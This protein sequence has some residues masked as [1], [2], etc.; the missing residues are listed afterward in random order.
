MA[1]ITSKRTDRIYPFEALI[2]LPEGGL[3][4][5]SKV[6]LRQLRSID[7]RRLTG[8]Y[9]QVSEETLTR[10]DAALRIAVGLIRL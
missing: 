9:G 1:A 5:R 3:S 6:M 8:Q 10:V 4:V 7:R 2:D